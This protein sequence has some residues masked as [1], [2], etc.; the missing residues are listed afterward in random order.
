[1]D[2]RI[3]DILD[4]T[5]IA[6][7]KYY[8]RLKKENRFIFAYME[9]RTRE[10]FIEYN[11]DKYDS[12]VIEEISQKTKYSLLECEKYGTESNGKNFKIKYRV[13][14]IINDTLKD[15]KKKYI[16][17]VEFV[18][19]DINWFMNDN[20][21][22]DF[23]PIKCCVNVNHLYLE[24]STNFGKVTIYKE[25]SFTEKTDEFNIK[26]DIVFKLKFDKEINYHEFRNKIYCFRNL[27]LI[28]GRRHLDIKK[29]KINECDLYDC[30]EEY[31]YRPLNDRYME[32]LDHHTI[33]IK[34]IDNFGDAIS[35]FFNIY[36]TIMPIIDGYFCNLKYTLPTKVKFINICS[37]IEDYANLFLNE[38]SKK[39]REKEANNNKEKFIKKIANKMLEQKIIGEKNFDSVIN[40]LEEEVKK[41]NSL[42]F[43]DKTISIIKN[44]NNSFEFDDSKI[45]LISDNFREVR[46]QIVHKGVFIREELYPILESYCS[47]IEDIIYLNILNEIGIDISNSI[48]KCIEF[49]YDKKDLI[50]EFQ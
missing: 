47:F 4:Q 14:R 42:T 36:D 39:Y 48:F 44:V 46:K 23:D 49:N 37:M 24:Y 10:E 1:M 30:Y 45:E 16:N 17:E 33:T 9:F 11:K 3:N 18:F 50:V 26:N 12:I 31:N 5:F 21:S 38:E 2:C 15:L 29:I 40:I 27:L 35:N 8:V 34:S 6:F 41:D 28:L 20:S 32:Y 43:K 22:Y 25:F 19:D 7:K 13:D